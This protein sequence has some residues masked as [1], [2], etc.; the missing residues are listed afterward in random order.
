VLARALAWSG[1]ELAAQV[2]ALNSETQAR[3]GNIPRHRLRDFCVYFE[4]FEGA[5]G[6]AS[7]TSSSERACLRP[8]SSDSVLSV[9]RGMVAAERGTRSGSGYTKHWLIAQ[10]LRTLGATLASLLTSEVTHVV[11]D[12]ERGDVSPLALARVAA[13]RAALKE[14]RCQPR[15]S[16][17]RIEPRVVTLQWAKACATESKRIAIDSREG[18]SIAFSSFAFSF[19]T[20]LIFFCPHLFATHEAE[21]KY[22]FDLNDERRRSV[23]CGGQ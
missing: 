22:A 19:L 9:S 8:T 1:A 13:L 2:R 14:L 7:G 21:A 4:G 5:G 18:T 3:L 6:G 12:L 10:T 17:R 11:V 23:A 15:A 16:G 20:H